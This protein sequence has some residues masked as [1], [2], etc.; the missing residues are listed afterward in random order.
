VSIL[1]IYKPPGPTSHDIVDQVR[2]I[3]G[4]RRVGHAGT[5]DPFA[6]GV[7]VVGVGREST[8]KLGEITKNTRK[9][10]VAVIEL[11]KTSDTGDPTGEIR[12]TDLYGSKRI[13]TDNK[14]LG[15]GSD[16]RINP[17]KSVLIRALKKFE[18]QFESSLGVGYFYFMTK[19][20]Y[21]EE[22]YGIRGACFDVYNELGGGIKET[23]IERALVLAFKSRGLDIKTQVR[24]DV[25]YAGNKIGTYIP[26]MVVNDKIVIEIKSKKFISDGDRK[27]FWGY[28]KGSNYKLGFLINFGS[29]QLVI[30]R[31]VHTEDPKELA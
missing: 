9:E 26:D 15:S 20:L 19:L 4:E 24:I 21:Q 3:T 16:I 13:Y 22:S 17:S 2:K 10:Y 30:K 31:F 18:G 27:Q 28:L 14:Q 12:S 29:N 6:E 11:G 7:L 1:N 5:L 8:K 23:I 25:N